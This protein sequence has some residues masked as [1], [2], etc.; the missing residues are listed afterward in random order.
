MTANDKQQRER[1]LE[2]LRRQDEAQWGAWVT[3]IVLPSDRRRPSEAA[4]ENLRQN[5]EQRHG[6]W[7]L[8]A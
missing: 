7:S 3:L 5:D 8:A 4:L 2:E 6:E 1:E